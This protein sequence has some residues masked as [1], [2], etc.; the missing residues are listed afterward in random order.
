MLIRS[1]DYTVQKLFNGY[2]LQK[3]ILS[4]TKLQLTLN[5]QNIHYEQNTNTNFKEY[6][7]L[8]GNLFITIPLNG[9]VIII[10][11]NIINNMRTFLYCTFS[12]GRRTYFSIRIR[13]A[14]FFL[15]RAI[16]WR[17]ASGGVKN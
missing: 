6:N 13:H 12:F 2:T 8:A 15:T 16:L 10:H 4:T 1:Y 11:I 5:I 14:P 3:Y 17:R 7:C 9:L